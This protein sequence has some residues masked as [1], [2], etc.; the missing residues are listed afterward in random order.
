MSADSVGVGSPR[1]KDS[2]YKAFSA[3]D[4]KLFTEVAALPAPEPRDAMIDITRR[5]SFNFYKDSI[6]LRNSSDAFSAAAEVKRVYTHNDDSVMAFTRKSG[7]E[8][9]LVVGSLNKKNL[10]GYSLPLPPGQWKEVLNSDAAEFGGSGVGNYG[11]VVAEAEPSH[12]QPA[13]VVL[14]LPPLG[15][16]FLS[17]KARR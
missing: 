4:K 17:P 5:Q 13:S 7:N 12:G 8:E 11:A 3:D 14:T 16:L 6:G 2:A 15:A 10:E 1:A 9:F